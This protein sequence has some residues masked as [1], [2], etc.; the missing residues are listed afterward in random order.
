MKNI[1]ILGA[2]G[3]IGQE[4]I[5]QI[6]EKQ[7]EIR[8][9]GLAS[10]KKYTTL[11]KG[12]TQKECL[13]F[14][15]KSDI[16]TNGKEM[17]FSEILSDCKNLGLKNLCFVD[18]TSSKKILDFHK[19][20]IFNSDYKIVTAN[21]NPLT[22]CSYEDFAKLTQN[23]L[24]YAFRSCVMAGADTIFFLQDLKQMNEE[25]I[26]IEGCFSGTLGYICSQLEEKKKFSQIVRQAKEKGYTEPHPRDDLNGFD[27]VRKL[28]LMGRV[29][30]LPINLENINLTPFIPENYFERENIEEFL[31]SLES[32][33]SDFF[34]KFEDARKTEETLKYVA[35][36]KQD[37]SG[38]YNCNVSLTQVPK[39]S[40][41]GSLSG[42][43]NKV[44][45]ITKNSYSKESPYVIQS[46]G[47]GIEVTAGNVRRDI[48][49]VFNK[50]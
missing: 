14:S 20:I 11:S 23:R 18:V 39:T 15:L 6:Y 2:T 10:S 48:N 22:I 9:V 42:T 47:A 13:D 21:K 50:I 40:V 43:S 33:D 38:K 17:N 27:V 3:N 26:E 25:I 24:R 8:I 12:F 28:L 35:N 4:L 19:E 32:L 34:K 16:F 29:I 37:S 7:K 31:S 44:S 30:G 45:I 46:P 49:Y 5:K 36:I 41:L 1:F